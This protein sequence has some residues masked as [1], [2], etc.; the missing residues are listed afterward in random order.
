[1]EKNSIPYMWRWSKKYIVKYKYYIAVMVLM[2]LVLVTLNLLQVNFIQRSVDAALAKDWQLMVRIIV[3]FL[4][5]TA[6][7]ILRNYI[8]G[9]ISNYVNVNV[10]KDLKNDFTQAIL[11]AE[12]RQIDNKSSGDLITKHNNDIAASLGYIRDSFINFLLNPLMALSGFVYLL[13]FN[14]KLS[15]FVF[16]STP[17]LSILLYCMSSR[18]SRIFKD[19]LGLQEIWM[20]DIYDTV[21]GAETIKSY[22]V[23]GYILKNSTSLLKRIFHKEV[24]YSLNDAITVGLILAVTYV[25][26]IVALLYGGTLV[27]N[28]EI[29][30]SVLFAY[31]QL[32]AIVSTPTINIFSSMNEM[33]NSYKS[34]K[35]L[36]SVLL[37]EKEQKDGN[38]Y[39]PEG[40][41]VLELDHV[42]FGYDPEFMVLDN[43][44][45]QL[46]KG[47][48]IGI[49]GDSGAGKSTILNL[50]CKFY[51]ANEGSVSISGH[52]IS[53]WNPDALRSNITYVS[54]ESRI[55]P[56]TVFE[57]IQYGR[58]DASREEVV[59]A[60]KKAGLHDFINGLPLGFD[61]VLSEN[62]TNLSGGQRQRIELARA[63]LRN[64]PIFVFDE[65][66]SAL[67]PETEKFVINSLQDILKQKS[68]II[69]SHKLSTLK[70]CDEIY[71][72][73]DGTIKEKGSVDLLLS[74]KGEFYNLFMC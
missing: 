63:F 48:C 64:A 30:I 36:D 66:T 41:T 38:A 54:Q 56:G 35:R 44:S 65:P 17:V 16:L 24:Q 33:K 59:E 15:V 53:D 11:N 29:S 43:V 31:S 2:I 32:I 9:Y 37:A 68:V 25:P 50:I 74:S 45:F 67:D 4:G 62:G 18:A 22:P 40:E 51:A 61:T 27:L 20:E 52:D 7:R 3:L 72:I 23:K 71:L 34:M 42:R 14:W 60:A 12:M 46:R 26:S 19:R 57:N 39:T 6:V 21:H 28:G 1:M 69:I 10:S 47:K 8:Y 13:F 5:I 73:Q 49:A 58:L 70:I 55:L